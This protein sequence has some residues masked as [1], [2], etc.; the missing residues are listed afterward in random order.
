MNFKKELEQRK[1][2]VEQIIEKY[3]PD[4]KGLAKDL[5]DRKSTRL[6]SSH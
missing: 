2:A 6:N 4:E 5:I 3:L 1:V